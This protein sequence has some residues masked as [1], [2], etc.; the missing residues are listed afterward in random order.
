MT[1]RLIEFLTYF[2]RPCWNHPSILGKSLF[3]GRR[4]IVKPQF[5]LQKLPSLEDRVATK[6]FDF[7]QNI[8]SSYTDSRWYQLMRTLF[9][10]YRT[11]LKRHH[12][13]AT[14]GQPCARVDTSTA[15]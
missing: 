5:E 15:F 2:I 13:V 12:G 6:Y 10:R 1:L 7:L 11:S 3:C 9:M 14:T 8:W 4:S